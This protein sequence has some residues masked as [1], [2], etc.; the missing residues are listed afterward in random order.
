MECI[1]PGSS[2]PGYT[3]E[4]SPE[5]KAL[6]AKIH[7]DE[8]ATKREE[9]LMK[10]IM[11]NPELVAC[12]A[13]CKDAPK[14][15]V[16]LEAK[17]EAAAAGCASKCT[18]AGKDEIRGAWNCAK[19][20]A[21]HAA[22]A[23]FDTTAEGKAI[24]GLVEADETKAVAEEVAVEAGPAGTALENE[25]AALSVTDEKLKEEEEKAQAEFERQKLSSTDSLA[26]DEHEADV[27]VDIDR[28]EG[29]V[30]TEDE[31]LKQAEEATD[32]NVKDVDET[33][34]KEDEQETERDEAK[35]LD[36]EK[37]EFAEKR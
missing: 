26:D 3:F 21:A 5:G 37:E 29:D 35:A 33:V 7:A 31:E 15:C 2:T 10:V 4:S 22:A 6:E 1:L 32:P 12:T 9:A 20:G 18:A 25:E 14:D 17:L 34:E 13:E 24:E 36:D 16:E 30:K 19:G 23:E 27:Q 8:A 11:A 28:V